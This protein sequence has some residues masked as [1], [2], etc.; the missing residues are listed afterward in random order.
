MSGKSEE[1]VLQEQGVVDREQQGQVHELPE[2]AR[3]TE[4][5][6]ENQMPSTQEQVLICVL[7]YS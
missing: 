2:E 5:N 7:I 1:V 4:K 6:E 3:Q